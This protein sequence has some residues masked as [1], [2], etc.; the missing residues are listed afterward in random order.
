MHNLRHQRLTKNVGR[1]SLLK[2][3]TKHHTNAKHAHA[4][5]VGIYVL[6]VVRFLIWSFYQQN[7]SLN[8]IKN[9][10]TLEI[11]CKYKQ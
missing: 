7:N 9:T 11:C 6:I 3:T 4:Y 10:L 1:T 8:A 2:G 5:S